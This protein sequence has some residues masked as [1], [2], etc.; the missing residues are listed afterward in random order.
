MDRRA[1]LIKINEIASQTPYSA[2][3][4]SLR[5]RQGKLK[6]K[7]IGDIWYTTCAHIDEYRAV[8]DARQNVSLK[9]LSPE[10]PAEDEARHGRQ[11]ARDPW[12][13]KWVAIPLAL[14]ILIGFLPLQLLYKSTLLSLGI[15]NDLAD[16]ANATITTDLSTAPETDSKTPAF[17]TNFVNYS[18][19]LTYTAADRLSAFFAALY[20]NHPTILAASHSNFNELNEQI[21]DRWG[22]TGQD[23]VSIVSSW[24]QKVAKVVGESVTDQSLLAKS[25]NSILTSGEA[26]RVAGV[27]D[28][29]IRLVGDQ[30]TFEVTAGSQQVALKTNQVFDDLQLTLINGRIDYYPKLTKVGAYNWLIDFPD[31]IEGDVIFDWLGIDQ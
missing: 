15:L 17:I 31:P 21:S 18:R 9:N 29:V 11:K 27:K 14:I 28:S 3:Y 16:D 10:N 5:A 30:G 25:D 22:L 20:A 4:L 12:L 7:K 13:V 19:T 26:G 6:A 24:S 23:S 8:Q 2:E 1:G